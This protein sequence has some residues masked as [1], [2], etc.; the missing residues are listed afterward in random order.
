MDDFFVINIA[1]YKIGVESVI[2]SQKIQ[3]ALVRTDCTSIF[4]FILFFLI[5]DNL[6]CYRFDLHIFRECQIQND[7][8]DKH[9]R[10]HIC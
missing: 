5:S 2:L 7:G 9:N 8:Y 1:Y 10:Y 3:P 6:L 4:I